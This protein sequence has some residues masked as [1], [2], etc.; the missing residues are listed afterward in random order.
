[1]K[2]ILFWLVKLTVS[3]GLM[4][5]LV[6]RVD[7]TDIINRVR[8]IMTSMLI[9]SSGLVILQI[10]ISSERWRQVMISIGVSLPLNWLIRVHWVG[11]FINLIVP[12]AVGCDAYRVWQVHKRGVMLFTAVNGVMLERIVTLL[13]LLIMVSTLLPLFIP[14]IPGQLG[15]RLLAV[16][17]IGGIGCL[18]MLDR[19]PTAFFRWRFVSGCSTLAKD[20]RRLFLSPSRLLLPMVWSFI[21]NA[22][23]AMSVC[24]IVYGLGEHLSIINA[25]IL[26]PP[27]MLVTSLPISVSGWGTREL[28]MVTALSFVGIP[29]DIALTTSILFGL[30][31]LLTSL[32]GGIF[33]MQRYSYT[34]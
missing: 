6:Y 8:N 10:V 27:V 29:T 4:V 1:M 31:I 19:V 28:A 13:S 21:G 26:I 24:T 25:L 14:N 5:L 34:R 30:I 2:N 12:G 3:I 22:N 9:L 16:A 7:I 20:T 33:M 23:L 18:M 11:A 32:T 17:G 15:F